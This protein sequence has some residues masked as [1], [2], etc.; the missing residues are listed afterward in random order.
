MAT[1][2]LGTNGSASQLCNYAEKRVIGKDFYHLDIDYAKSQMN[3][4]R[5]LYS[6]ND[7]IQSHHVIQS[8]KP[9]E[10]TPEKAYQVG[11]ELA[12]KLSPNLEVAVYPHVDTNHV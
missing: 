6:K 2:Q 10:V 1:I 4:T 11:L 5:E 3:Q 9:D 7:R 8:F 12:I